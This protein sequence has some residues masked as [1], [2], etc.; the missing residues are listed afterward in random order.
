MESTLGRVGLWFGL[1][2]VAVLAVAAAKDT[3]FAIHMVIVG[4]AAFI[5]LW[6]TAGNYNPLARAQSIFHM[7]EGP[8][9]YDDDPVRW[10]V[11]AT[12]FWGIAGFLAGLFIALQLARALD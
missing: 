6:V 8:S 3:G 5:L 7:P 9:R 11:L 1:L 12:M 4:A 10:G 2:I